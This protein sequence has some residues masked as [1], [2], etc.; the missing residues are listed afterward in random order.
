MDFLQSETLEGDRFT[1]KC[2]GE[3]KAG[4]QGHPSAIRLENG[5]HDELG[6]RLLDLV[7]EAEQ[8]QAVAAAAQF[9]TQ[10]DV[11]RIQV[12]VVSGASFDLNLQASAGLE[13]N[14][15][16]EGERVATE[17]AERDPVG[18][19]VLE[20]EL[21]VEWGNVEVEIVQFFRERRVIEV[22]L[23]TVALVRV[24][25]DRGRRTS[26][27][28]R[29]AVEAD[30]EERPDSVV[31]EQIELGLEIWPVDHTTADPLREQPVV[32][33]ADVLVERTRAVGKGGVHA[34]RAEANDVGSAIAAEVDGQTEM[35]TDP[36]AR[37]VR[38]LRRHAQP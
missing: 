5:G 29:G 11:E 28:V 13:M 15:E 18:V 38:E 2:R 19:E 25:R 9:R 1:A 14:V 3:L 33:R 23:G 16:L 22:V 8:V 31:E 24:D 6:E 26:E 20:V 17:H 37:P 10:R 27:L 30:L 21:V 36:P 34:V 4:R 12:D 7:D 35:R 32:E